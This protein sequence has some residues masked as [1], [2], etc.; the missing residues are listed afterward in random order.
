VHTGISLN[1]ADRRTTLFANYSWI[2]REDDNDGA[3]SLPADTYDLAAEWAPAS[4]IP[5]HSFSG[6]LTTR[7]LSAFRL[8][9]TATAHTGTPYN[10]TTGRD[11]NGD[12]VFTD[13][14]AGTRRNSGTQ[15][16]AWD[17]AARLSYAFGFGQRPAGGSGG[18]MIMIQRIG[19]PASAG[20]MLGGSGDGGP[21]DKRVRF[22]L[23]VSAQNL[24]NNV[25]PVGFSGVMTSPFFG[26]P[27][28][29]MPAR[30][31]DVGMHIGF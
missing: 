23:Y 26:R 7:F 17:T 27:T 1:T 18:P 25:N 15:R 4:S 3:F 2:H 31:I 16:G 30:R 9:L 10:I 29:A 5:R 11:D 6:M 13:R 21:E 14:P 28:A 22:E 24:F 8:G 12:T 20:D 19:G